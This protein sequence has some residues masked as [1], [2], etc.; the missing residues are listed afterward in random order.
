LCLTLL[1]LTGCVNSSGRPIT[2][3]TIPGDIKTCIS[4]VTPNPPEGPWTKAV[5]VK[6]IADLKKSEAS[7]TACGKR[8]IKLYESQSK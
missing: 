8:L 6:F 5:V 1:T 2:L 3:A 4:Q 7:K